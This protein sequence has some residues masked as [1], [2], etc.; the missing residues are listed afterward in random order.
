[1]WLRIGESLVDLVTEDYQLRGGRGRSE[2]G[3]GVKEGV[4]SEREGGE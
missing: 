1:M 4:R 3:R 2:G